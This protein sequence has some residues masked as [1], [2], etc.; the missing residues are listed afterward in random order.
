VDVLAVRDDALSVYGPA[1]QHVLRS[2]FAAQK[3][4]LESPGRATEQMARRLQTP[5]SEV[6]GLYRGLRLPDLANNRLMLAA[7][8]TVDQTAQD[9]QRVMVEAGLLR[10]SSVL[11]S[12]SDPR[13][14]P[15]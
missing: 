7:G 10:P 9:L 6:M 11:P 1:L 3:L 4:L 14:L 12:L 8:G 2:Y 5:A 15:P 13:F